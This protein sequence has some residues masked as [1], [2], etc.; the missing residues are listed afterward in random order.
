M[1]VMWLYPFYAICHS[2]VI[3]GFHQIHLLTVDTILSSHVF[4][5][6]LRISA[7]ISQDRLSRIRSKILP[8]KIKL[9]R[10][11]K[12]YPNPTPSRHP[13]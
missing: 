12:F 13:R 10:G 3:V 7:P 6:R 2:I 8:E 1:L 9:R 5:D 11:V 4:L